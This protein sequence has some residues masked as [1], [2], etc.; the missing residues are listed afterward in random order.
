MKGIAVKEIRQE[1]LEHMRRLALEIDYRVDELERATA[2]KAQA[3]GVGTVV[4]AHGGQV[5]SIQTG[6][7]STVNMVIDQRDRD[8]LIAAL[9]SL[10]A[11]VDH[12]P[13]VAVHTK[14]ELV[15][16]IDDSKEAIVAERPS[17]ARIRGLLSGTGQVVQT[18][19]NAGAAWEAVKAAAALIGIPLP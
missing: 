6:A 16:L 18:L 7:Q 10:R 11:E 12:T 1:T 5:G 19:G 13:D 2:P 8:S 17:G 14:T 3:D 15:E 9:E 4:N